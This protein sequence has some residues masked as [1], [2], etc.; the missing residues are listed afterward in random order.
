MKSNIETFVL[1]PG[2]FV[3]IFGQN[4]DEVI[5]IRQHRA[6]RDE[7]VKKILPIFSKRIGSSDYR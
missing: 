5:T 4:T 3:M 2:T 6:E 1:L 7:R